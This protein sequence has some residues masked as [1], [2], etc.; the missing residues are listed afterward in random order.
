MKL[1]E[2]YL[3]TNKYDCY[4]FHHLFITSLVKLFQ[5]LNNMVLIYLW[6]EISKSFPSI[7]IFFFE[8]VEFDELFNGKIY[9]ITNKQII[10]NV[11]E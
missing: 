11:E 3:L 7:I 6:K 2:I 1:K 10:N 4:N 5:M 9:F 8:I